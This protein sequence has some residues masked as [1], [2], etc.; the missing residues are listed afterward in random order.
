MKICITGLSQFQ[1]PLLAT[2]SFMFI[3]R[4]RVAGACAG[5]LSLQSSHMRHVVVKWFA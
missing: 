4:M 2:S 1:S 3:Q 5:I